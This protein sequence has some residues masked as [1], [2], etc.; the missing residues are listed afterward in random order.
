MYMIQYGIKVFS[1]PLFSLDTK[2]SRPCTR[3]I[4]MFLNK[5]S[6]CINQ[7]T[8]SNKSVNERVLEFGVKIENFNFCSLFEKSYHSEF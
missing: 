8:K 6:D 7:K 1:I 2:V 3:L 5:K 4:N